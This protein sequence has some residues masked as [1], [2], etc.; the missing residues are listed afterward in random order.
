MQNVVAEPAVNSS[1]R[2]R[3]SNHLIN[4]ASPLLEL[5]LKMRA[6]VIVPSNEVR[7]V[8]EDLLKQLETG[9]AQVGCLPQQ[10]RDV[11][12]ALVAFIDETVLSP[13]NNFPFR[14]E[15]EREPLQLMHF[16]EHLAGMK[17]FEKLDAM[18][19]DVETNVDVIEVYYL[20]LLLGFKGK[21][22]INLL[23]EQLKQVIADVA[24]RLQSVGRLDANQ[25]SPNWQATDQPEMPRDKGLPVWAKIGGISLLA[26]VILTYIILYVL[27]QRE[28]IVVR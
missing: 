23:E 8:A 6:G 12:F 14:S 28:L 17:F 27:L 26:V 18:A 24:G 16:E 9:G 20:C 25:L 21:Y 10:I 13:R 4:L 3:S 11:K 15:W 7:P 1:R 2:A 19:Q 22:N 5:A